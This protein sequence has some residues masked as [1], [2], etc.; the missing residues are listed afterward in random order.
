MSKR[1][2]AVL[3]SI[4]VNELMAASERLR[5]LT[6]QSAPV[7]PHE[8]KPWYRIEASSSDRTSVY[9]YD[10]IGEWGVTALDFVGELRNIRTPHIEMHVNTPGGQIFD[11]LAIYNSL[12]Q[13]PAEVTTYVDGVAASAGSFII[14]ASDRIIMAPS[15]SIMV[16]GGQGL[17][18]GGEEDMLEMAALLGK[19]NDQ[20]AGV[21]AQ[22]SETDAKT[23]RKTMRS[24]KWYNAEEAVAAGL[25][26]EVAS[27][28]QTN[29]VNVSDIKAT[30]P[31]QPVVE[32]DID[33]FL[34]NLKE[35]CS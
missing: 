14:Q 30:Q 15:A 26:D 5:Y 21:Y 10:A 13:H 33:Q 25:A 20:I 24:D 6:A 27:G 9:L 29:T 34:N 3:N 2:A 18:M 22:R 17:C 23:W 7:V 1:R 4:N 19:L 31:E 12:L 28:D 35:A 16:H 11:G 32:W 8:V